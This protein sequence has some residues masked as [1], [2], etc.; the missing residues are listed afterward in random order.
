ME[1]AGEAGGVVSGVCPGLPRGVREG[2]PG[3][4]ASTDFRRC[5]FTELSCKKT[6]LKTKT[7][8]VFGEKG[9]IIR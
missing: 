9:G 7:F 5:L 6:D 8:P 4:V 2:L 1:W 3:G